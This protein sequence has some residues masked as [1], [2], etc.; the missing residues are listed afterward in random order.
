VHVACHAMEGINVS[1]PVG[2]VL[3]VTGWP[4]PLRRSRSYNLQYIF[5]IG[6]SR[7]SIFCPSIIL[8]WWKSFH[9]T[10]CTIRTPFAKVCRSP[11]RLPSRGRTWHRVSTTWMVT[12]VPT[13][14]NFFATQT[15]D[16]DSS[17]S[18]RFRKRTFASLDL[19]SRWTSITRVCAAK[20]F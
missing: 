17:R 20:N 2:A 6:S 12:G 7:S 8:P 13:R 19:V 18:P 14:P 11:P 3:A 16:S 15:A 10:T 4:G 5:S 1:D 9:C